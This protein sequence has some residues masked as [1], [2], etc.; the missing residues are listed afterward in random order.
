M[1]SLIGGDLS[2]NR[3][4]DCMDSNKIFKVSGH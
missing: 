3:E 1:I 2:V 4:S